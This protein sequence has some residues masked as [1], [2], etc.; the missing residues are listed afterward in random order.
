MR[1]AAKVTTLTPT[2]AQDHGTA[3]G[4]QVCFPHPWWRTVL[5]IAIAINAVAARNRQRDDLC[6]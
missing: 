5:T 4:A 1:P 3:G 6:I 2:A